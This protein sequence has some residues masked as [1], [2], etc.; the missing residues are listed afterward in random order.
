[1]NT[2]LKNAYHLEMQ[3]ARSL[4]KERDYK[5]AF[6]HLERAHVLGQRFFVAH[7]VTHGWMLRV[8]WAQRDVN[9]IAGQVLRLA[10]TPLGHL[11]GRL[12]LGN[13]GGA[14]VNAFKPMPLS[15]EVEALLREAASQPDA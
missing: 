15:K 14:N 11:T 9:E 7:T 5:Q 12:P 2:I 1:M 4:F 3:K 6:M 10:L 13:T 8:G